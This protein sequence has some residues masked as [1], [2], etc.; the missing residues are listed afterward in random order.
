MLA[1]KSGAPF[2]NDNFAWFSEHY[3]HF[4][5]IDRAVI[6]PGYQGAKLGTALYRDLFSFARKENV[7]L[8][9]CEVYSFPPNER[10]LAFHASLGFENIGERYLE[11]RDKKVAMQALWLNKSPA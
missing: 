9:G 8:I 2:D 11:D 7:P 3:D 1:M 4:Y 10:S 5:Y 6:K